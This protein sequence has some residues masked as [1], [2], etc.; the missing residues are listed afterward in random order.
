MRIYFGIAPELVW[1]GEIMI[2]IAKTDKKPIAD[3][4][5]EAVKNTSMERKELVEMPT[6]AVASIM[7]PPQSPS[8]A[9]KQS[10]PK[11]DIL[12]QQTPA[13]CIKTRVFFT[14]QS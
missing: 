12:K 3:A 5:R 8:W 2:T 13:T 7:T 6:M 9:S 1:F 11:W 14:Y 4:A 10:K